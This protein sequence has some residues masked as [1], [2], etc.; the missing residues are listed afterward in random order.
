MSENAKRLYNDLAWLWPLWSDPITGY[1]DWCNQVTRLIRQYS[2]RDVHT[3][4]NMGCGGGKNVFN[5]KNQFAV[6]GVDISQAMLDL[7]QHLNP[8]CNFIL[9]DMRNCSLGQEF[10]AVLVDDA[11]SYMAS[12]AELSAVFQNA[13]HHLRVGG[14][15]VVAP[16]DTIETFHQNRT[17]V[18]YANAKAKPDNIDVAFI[19]NY[20]DP[21]PSDDTYEGTFVYLIRDSGKLRIETDHHVLG[22]FSLNV[23]RTALHEAGFEVYE[24]T[25]SEEQDHIMFACVKCA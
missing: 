14:V 15:M 17:Q 9:G 2:K 6:T 12:R 20:Y 5:L 13:Y 7:A 1:A 25:S 21:N 3:L 8:E 16:D 23:W 11:I 4:L 19:E 22:L 24:E 18:N 10:D